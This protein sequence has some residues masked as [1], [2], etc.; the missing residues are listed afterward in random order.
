M[1]SF[2]IYFRDLNEDAQ[3]RLC[4]RYKTT[5]HEEYADDF[6]NVDPI[7]TVEREDE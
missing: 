1:V 7:A 5:P 2:D 6:S 3:K 4:D